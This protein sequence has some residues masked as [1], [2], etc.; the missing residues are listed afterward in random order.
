MFIK[1]YLKNIISLSIAAVTALGMAV[2][3]QAAEPY[4]PYIYD[5]WDDAIPSQNSYRI[6]R[7]I[8]GADMGLDRLSDP[9]DPLFISENA[10]A[11]L[12]NAKDLFFDESLKEFWIADSD[13]NRVLRLDEEFHLTG[14]YTGAGGVSFAGPQGIYAH[15]SLIDTGR[16]YIYIADTDNGRIVKA[17]A[18]SPT[19]LTVVQEY[20][21]PETEL[22]TVET[23]TPQK[24]VADAAENVYS[25][26]SSVN[27]GAVQFNKAGEFQG[28]YGANRVEVTASVIA[29]KL[30]RKFA[31]NEQISGMKRNVPVEYK[32]FDIDEDGFIYTVTEAA[33]ATTDAVKK[34]NPAGYNIW[35]N[36]AGN[37]YRFGDM[38]S[39]YDS[40]ANLSYSTRLT[41]IC[42]GGNGL[43]NVLDFET[44]RVFQY[45]RNANLLCIFGAKN[46]NNDQR[47]T[48]TNPNA[49][50]ANGSN[51]Y[52]LDGSKNDV[53]VFTETTFGSLMHEAV[54]LYDQ[55]RYTEAKPVW[56]SV[57]ARDGGYPLAYVGLG[58]AAMNDGEYS[59][60]LEYFKVAYD[61]DDYDKAY[62]YAR[63][64]FIRDNFT[65]MAVI[66][67]LLFIWLKV[68][69]I[70]HKRGIFILKSLFS[71]EDK[72]DEPKLGMFDHTPL[73]WLRYS[74]FHPI[75]GFED[76]RWKKAGSLKISAVIVFMLFVSLVS[77][78]QLTGFQFNHSYVKVFNVVPLI[79]QS[80]LYYLAWVVGNWSVCTLLEGEG[81]LKRIAVFSA[82][83]L[84]PYVVCTLVQVLL[85]NFLVQ[86]EAIWLNALYYLSI[87]WSLVLMIQAMKAC[88][89]YSFSKTIASM[90]LTIVAML[91]I[92]FLLILLLSL[93]QQVYVFFYSIYTEIAYRIKG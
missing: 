89:Q 86:E 21:R 22:Y 57:I 66:V 77:L 53:T 62:K 59:K 37:D 33:N 46:S 28:Y 54:E 61:R 40:M 68:L 55:G 20:K 19:E 80:V 67:I 17:T 60:A 71:K 36:A 34:L 70:L 78:R 73:G 5:Y 42:I 11:G 69:G 64:D 88:H 47:G 9:A 30:W 85:S 1:R 76:M 43:I 29:Q 25:V 83:S 2:H 23:F 38:T 44:G 6:E 49:I 8:T 72:K 91:L 18:D 45:D 81:T 79:V 87:G 35:N 13:N 32:N 48:F 10:P 26:V 90:L 31:S 93:F 41:D 4:K 27:Q 92:L 56:E 3:V 84:T 15:P 16:L 58:K 74:V 63:K 50:D 82:Y 39:E 7:T 52:V 65:A 14:C 24:V 12:A 75:E 51:I